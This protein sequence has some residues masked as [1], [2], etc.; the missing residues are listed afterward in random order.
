[1]NMLAVSSYG[2]HTAPRSASCT[3]GWILSILQRFA[4]CCHSYHF[5]GDALL[6]VGHRTCNSQFKGS[7]PGWAP[8][9]SG[10][11]QAT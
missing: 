4:F 6:L 11:G 2:K 7:S 10:L 3:A 9:R 8:P 1:M 5:D